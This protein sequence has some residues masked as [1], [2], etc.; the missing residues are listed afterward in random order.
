MLDEPFYKQSVHGKIV[1]SYI[2]LILHFVLSLYE[3]LGCIIS[4]HRG[5]QKEKVTELCLCFRLLR[6]VQKGEHQLK[7]VNPVKRRPRHD[8]LL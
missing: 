4:F 2:R 6:L 5:W 7:A 1:F 8:K 3:I